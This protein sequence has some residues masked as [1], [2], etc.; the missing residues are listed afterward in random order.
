MANAKNRNH[1]AEMAMQVDIFMTDLG[2]L[3]VVQ[4]A[5]LALTINIF[6]I[7]LVNN[8]DALIFRHSYVDSTTIHSVAIVSIA[9]R[10]NQAVSERN[11]DS[12]CAIISDQEML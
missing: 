7:I 8:L 4:P 1:I 5:T 6:P 3:L 12:A 9:V 2:A 11:Y 10:D